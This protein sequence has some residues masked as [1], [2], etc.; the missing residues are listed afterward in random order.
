MKFA[1]Y[2]YHHPDVETL[3]KEI[4]TIEKQLQEASD[5]ESFWNA[6]MSFDALN[7][8]L[9]TDLNLC[10]IRHTINTKDSYYKQEEDYLNEIL[11]I[12][13]EDLVRVGNVILESPYR[14]E[15]EKKIPQTYFWAKELE[16]KCFSP[17]VIEDLQIENKASSAYQQLV[18]GAQVEFE[19]QSYTLSQLEPL[20]KS[21]DRSLRKRATKAY[22]GWFE[23]NEEE[24]ASIFD[25]LVKTRDRIAKKLGYENFIGCGYDRMYRFD[26][27]QKDVE[28]YRQQV[29]KTVVPLNNKLYERQKNRL[30]VDRLMAWD[31]KVEFVSGNPK[32]KH[33]RQTMVQLALQMYRELSV[34]TGE[35]FAYMIDHDLM[36]LD[37]KPGK[38]AG[39]YCTYLNDYD[40]PFI[41]ANFNQT[42][43]DVE[44]L[45]HE[46][47]HAYQAYSSKEIVPMECI[48]PTSES[49]E[50]HSMSMEFL[51]Y[52][53]MKNFFLE[54]TQKFIFDHLS[55]A[56]KFLPYGVLVDH[57]QHEVY[58]H[59]EK[60]H[61]WRMQTWRELE[62]QYLPHKDY[63]EMELLERGGWWM[64]QLH[65]FMDPFYYIDYTLAQVCALQFWARAQKKDPD[66]FKDYQRICKLGGSLPF[67]QIVNQAH[68]KDPFEEGCLDETIQEVS[69]A[70][71]SI[72]DEE[73]S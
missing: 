32:P 9:S 31:E 19:G 56:V 53:W 71:E 7:Q 51:T 14:K 6:F 5:F 48:W 16:K 50:I 38:A 42:S 17:E 64:R 44:V 69:A 36:D 52:P 10:E 57:F 22:W 47:G 63:E 59:P 28:T 27:D 30:G 72:T 15:L 62:K 13:Q 46:A 29:L 24:L 68:L 65:I 33:D 4:Q 55:G 58:A 2:I 60:D 11:P 54:D 35:F 61:T 3:K 34:E 25:T 49:A 21:K 1:D 43:G 40:A 8:H 45:T 41:F 66:T 20:M 12:V 18:A 67:K 70:L 73:L 37:S 23:E 39:G 26:Y